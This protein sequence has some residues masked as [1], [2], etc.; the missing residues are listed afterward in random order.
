MQNRSWLYVPGDDED[1]LGRAVAI[2]ADAIVVDLADSIQPHAR[3]VARILTAEWLAIHRHQITGR[4]LGRWVRI[5]AIDTGFWRE[6]VS[7]AMQ[8]APD[9]FILPR[10]AGPEAVQ[11]LA[12]EIYIQEEANQISSGSTRIIPTVGGTAQSALS[13]PAYIDA[14]LPRLAGLCWD[15]AELCASL[16]ALREK[17]EGGGW[18]Q[19]LRFVRG[20]LLLAAHARGI[21]AIDTYH[22]D[23]ADAEGLRAAAWAMRADGFTGMMA[24][25]PAQ[26]PAIHA[27]F[28]PRTEPV[29]SDDQPEEASV[30]QVKP[31]KRML[32]LDALAT[33]PR[34]AILRS[35]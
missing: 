2:G 8:G 23:P 13:V 33:E 21:P 16:G 29:D 10:A 26:I 18:T 22:P 6:D 35:A 17:D 19:T 32:D 4:P 9:G 7:A 24:I 3:K 34:G 25:D 20:Q 30:L 28:T 15:P 1:A 14:S 5:N 31:G 11:A 27:A 12:A